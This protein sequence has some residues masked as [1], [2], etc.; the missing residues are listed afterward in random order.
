MKEK[1]QNSDGR[2]IRTFKLGRACQ[3]C[4]EPI[5]D[6]ARATKMHCTRWKDEFGTVHDCKRRKH[7]LKHQP[8]E[9]ILLDFSAKQR[10]TS[11]QIE[12]VIAAHG[13]I[14]S[15]EVLNAYNITLS[16]NLNYSY[17]SGLATAEF[18]GYKIITNPRLNNHKIEKI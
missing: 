6:Q 9:D 2:A 13:D 18:L 10:E 5:E 15:T 8:Q 12:K 4:G 11:Q 16:D 1:K 14:V 7:Q 17:H 3:Y